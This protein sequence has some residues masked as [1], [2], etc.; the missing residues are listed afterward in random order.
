MLLRKLLP[1][2]GGHGAAVLEVR[3]VADEHDGHVR[4]GVLWAAWA[5]G[6]GTVVAQAVGGT[7]GGVGGRPRPG[8]LAVV[9]PGCLL[10]LACLASSSQEVRWLKVSRLRAPRM[11]AA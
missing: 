6:G 9:T 7:G 8:P 10:G 11:T 2:L 5:G 3:L 4:V 1:L